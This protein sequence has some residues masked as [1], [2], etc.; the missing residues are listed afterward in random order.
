[1][2][3]RYF[4]YYFTDQPKEVHWLTH[5][6]AVDYCKENNCKMIRNG[7]LQAIKAPRLKSDKFKGHEFHPGLGCYVEDE[8]H[9]RQLLKERGLIE[10]RELEGHN[11][12]IKESGFLDDD[13][14]RELS[15]ISDVSD[16]ELDA[17]KAGEKLHND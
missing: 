10:A 16:R 5:K 15:H 6:E 8:T 9:Y 14:C 3:Q 1:M 4:M 17:I 12:Q 7:L 2:R 13:T 11:P